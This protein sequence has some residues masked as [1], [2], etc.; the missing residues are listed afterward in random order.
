VHRFP[1]SLKGC[2]LAGLALGIALL[3][4]P[5]AGCGPALA[6][7][8]RHPQPV[9]SGT[10]PVL[11]E[12]QPADDA[13]AVRSAEVALARWHPT[14]PAPQPRA[15]ASS[16]A[17]TVSRV[18]TAE[19]RTAEREVAAAQQEVSADQSELD[20]LLAEQEQ[21][22]DPSAY[23]GQVAAAR[24]ELDQSVTRLAEARRALTAARSR[25]TTVRVTSTG[26][27]RPTPTERATSGRQELVQALAEARQVQAAHLAARKQAVARWRADL[28]AETAHVSAHNARVRA[29]A[30][31]SGVSVS[32]G[33][34]LLALSAGA[35]LTR[36]LMSAR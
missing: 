20:R 24:E 2:A 26:S 23:D 30:S 12:G 36:R 18:S 31:R 10:E 35:L 34:G 32:V 1:L 6:A 15:S 11:D 33:F 4:V 25:T 5:A 7:V 3:A 16:R 19:V 21:A 8:L 17:V 22:S 29:C 9:P 27:P 28:Q 13:A 14:G